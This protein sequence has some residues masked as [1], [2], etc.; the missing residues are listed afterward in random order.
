MAKA[1]EVSYEERLD[2]LSIRKKE[3]VKFSVDLAL[4]SGDVI[5]D[6]G[7]DGLVKGLEIMNASEF[8]SKSQGELSNLKNGSFVVIYSPNYASITIQLEFDS[9]KNFVKSNLV[10]PYS[11]KLAISA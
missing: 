3:K 1:S 10:L 5:V 4:S 2:I 6:I 11:R 8:F 7:N 9:K